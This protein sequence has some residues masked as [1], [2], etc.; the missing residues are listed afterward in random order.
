MDRQL[1]KKYTD[2]A[3]EIGRNGD[4]SALPEL[5]RY[6]KMPSQH[7]RRLSA[8]AI[9]KLAGLL[10]AKLA[11][12]ALK[13]MLN[14]PHP[15]VKQ[16]VIKALSAYG[17]EAAS[18]LNDLK[19][20]A[21]N[22]IEKEYNRR[23]A[24]KALAL[25]SEAVKLKEQQTVHKCSRCSVNVVSDEY[26]R[27]MKAFQRIYCSKCFDEVYLKRRNF[28]TEVELNKTIEAKSG[29]LVQSDGE[30]LI[31]DFLH[32]NNIDF[33]YDE[34]IRLIEGFAVR[35]DFYLPEFDVYIEYWGMDTIDYKIGMMKKQKLYQ[36]EGKK[37]IPIYPKDKNNLSTLLKE[38]LFRYAPM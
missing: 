34:R 10:D 27:S 25:I 24:E 38:K 11:V 20:I 19:D 31:A 4:V 15:Q 8:S 21:A 26:A 22:Y 23:D 29:T 16:Y 12:D 28:D 7:V 35:P 32:E 18:A 14:D 33:R 3:V 5:I 30:R 6:L 37:L 17:A 2:R 36:Q 9:G 13:S 1:E